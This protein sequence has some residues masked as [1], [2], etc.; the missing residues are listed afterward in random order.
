M[1]SPASGAQSQPNPA[2]TTGDKPPPTST[3]DKPT[4]PGKNADPFAPIVYVTM[5]DR[6]NGL[7]FCTGTLVASRK[8]VTAAHC[9][10]PMFVSFKIIAPHSPI[11]TT[12]SASNP[13][14]FGQP[15][16]FEDVAKP[17]AGFLTLDSPIALDAYAALTDVVARVDAGEALEVAAVVRTA[18]KPQAPLEE[19]AHLPLSSTVEYGYLHGF[20]TP[21]FTKGGD[22]G[23]GLFL[24]ENG[25]RTD[26]LVG[27]ARQPEP[28]RGIDHFT[29]VDA[30]F[31]AWFKANAG[32]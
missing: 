11:P 16:D 20:G 15:M 8:V 6:Q 28:A 27:I 31:L 14:V 1:P 13:V 7:W 29:R 30:D 2:S 4:T 10:D 3:G 25:V 12:V 23:A 17:D 5:R 26:K 22:S 18:E 24:V 19:A 21:M 32:P 9:L